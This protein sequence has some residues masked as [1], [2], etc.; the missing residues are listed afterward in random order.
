MRPL[1]L[2][3]RLHQMNSKHREDST[4]SSQSISTA[5]QAAAYLDGL[6]NLERQPTLS[7][8]RLGLEPIRALLERVGHPERELSVVH[9]AGSKG[10][11][12]TALFAE[13]VLGAAGER[14][15]TFTS[16]HLQN[17]TERFRIAG[18]EV[19]GSALAASVERLRPHIDAL[20]RAG[21][22][23]TP[24]F[25]DATTAA[26]LLLF[27]EAGVDR[28]VLEV[29]LGGR[30]DS[31][32]IVAPAV[33]CI[34]SIELEHTDKL[35]DSLDQ[36]AVEKAGILKPGVPC[37]IGRLPAPARDAVRARAN[38]L[39]APLFSLDVDFSIDVVGGMTAAQGPLI[40]YREP[41]GFEVEA[42]LSVLGE[43]QALNAALAVAA[44]RRLG[45]HLDGTLAA[46]AA[47]GLAAA[48]LPGRVELVECSPR[49]V[50]DSAHTAASARALAAALASIPARRLHFVL[51]VSAGKDL[52]AI[53]A[54][55]LPLASALTLTRAEA[56]RSLDPTEL[57]VAVRG[58]DPQMEIRIVPNPQLA[59]RTAHAALAGDEL[60]CVAGSVYLA[61]IARDVFAGGVAA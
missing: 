59:L 24:S 13:S 49:V 52:K 4:S 26:A 34:T 21:R 2:G 3:G 50:I 58:V 44:I 60:L 12:S 35:G 14:V 56:R 47:K 19:S 36:I 27:A 6:I 37:V 42:Q 1:S 61:G 9:V 7:Q 16:P 51:S 5:A 31:T 25:F 17:W 33:T 41:D 43:H 28:A 22:G 57:S 48:A 23:P 45:A 46:A 53:L 10:K 40:R 29:G 8:A 15:G 20:N 54:P 55:L 18:R 30:L 38:E 32:N 11:G 39:A